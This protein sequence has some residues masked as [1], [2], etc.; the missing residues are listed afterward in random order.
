MDDVVYS[1]DLPEGLVFEVNGKLIIGTKREEKK[2]IVA[3]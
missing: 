3:V 2:L 1:D